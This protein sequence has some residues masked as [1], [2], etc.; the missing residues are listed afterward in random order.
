MYTALIA[1]K[2]RGQR[3]RPC[4]C[5]FEILCLVCRKK[6]SAALGT[7]CEKCGV[8][9]PTDTKTCYCHRVY[10][11]SCMGKIYQSKGFHV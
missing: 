6:H 11:E 8:L 2:E 5:C 9:V 7:P 3:Q 10:C 4:P 1:I